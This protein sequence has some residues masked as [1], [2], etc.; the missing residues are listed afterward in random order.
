MSKTDGIV[1]SHFLYTL[2]QNGWS[3]IQKITRRK[4]LHGAH[5]TGKILHRGYYAVAR[6]YEF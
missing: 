6:R 2:K 1:A 4:G 3:Y 5:I